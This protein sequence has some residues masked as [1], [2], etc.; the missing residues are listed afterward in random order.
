MAD[1]QSETFTA[2]FKVRETIAVAVVFV[3]EKLAERTWNWFPQWG[4]DVALLFVV[5]A[6]VYLLWTQPDVGRL[7][8]RIAGGPKRMYL[9]PLLIGLG[10]AIGASLGA[11][12]AWRVTKS[13]QGKEHDQ[14]L[15]FVYA[16]FRDA[17]N[18]HYERLGRRLAR[19]QAIAGIYFAEHE[20][21]LALWFEPGFMCYL[22]GKQNHRLEEFDDPRIPD[23]EAAY[24]SDATNRA[25]PEI[26]IKQ[27]W[28]PPRGA[29]AKQWAESPE[30]INWIG[31]RKC[32]NA[33]IAYPP[34]TT[35]VQRFQRGL[36]VGV[37]Q[38]SPNVTDIQPAIFVLFTEDHVW[39]REPTQDRPPANIPIRDG[40]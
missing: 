19:E 15:P 12:G 24:N 17:Y 36:I 39:R 30:T 5:S 34:G 14:T 26:Q 33:E 22:L 25:R 40:H 31:G 18:V 8:N 13:Q 23:D 21:A 1:L 4:D 20:R 38:A 16:P 9:Y 32:E 11:Y 37:I 2:R 10:V 6:V 7:L 29:F 3:L 35:Y 27:G 28:C